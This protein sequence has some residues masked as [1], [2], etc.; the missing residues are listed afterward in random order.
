MAGSK[1]I[2][3]EGG[4]L[5]V[6]GPVGEAGVLQ[7]APLSRPATAHPPLHLTSLSLH[8]LHSLSDSLRYFSVSFF[9]PRT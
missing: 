1:D 5:F 8:R 6:K 9:V 7:D 3:A 2:I 4:G